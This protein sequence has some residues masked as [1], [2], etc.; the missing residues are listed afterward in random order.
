[1]KLTMA[2]KW[3]RKAKVASKT[4]HLLMQPTSEGGY[5]HGLVDI[6]EP[7]DLN[8]CQ[9]IHF[10]FKDFWVGECKIILRSASLSA[11]QLQ[12]KDGTKK[13]PEILD[14][15]TNTEFVGHHF[16]RRGDR[17]PPTGW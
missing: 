2:R 17:P 15:E 12:C 5:I 9:K 14:N 11:W 13:H 10:L 16:L 3:A 6:L 8:F 1:M 7:K 4:L